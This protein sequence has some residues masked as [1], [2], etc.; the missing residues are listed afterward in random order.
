MR[1]ERRASPTAAGEAD[2]AQTRYS[3]SLRLPNGKHGRWL[4]AG[5]LFGESCMREENRNPNHQPKEKKCRNWVASSAQEKPGFAGFLQLSPTHKRSQNVKEQA[6]QKHNSSQQEH[7]HARSAAQRYHWEGP[8]RRQDTYHCSMGCQ[9]EKRIVCD[10]LHD[11]ERR[12]EPQPPETEHRRNQ[13]AANLA[14]RRQTEARAAVGSG[15]KFGLWLMTPT[16]QSDPLRVSLYPADFL[17]QNQTRPGP[18]CHLV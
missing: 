12:A 9:R 15:E 3:N 14:P 18:D 8:Q 10:H 1:A 17:E 7:R 16:P 2:G 6:W 4:G 13:R 11:A 5:A